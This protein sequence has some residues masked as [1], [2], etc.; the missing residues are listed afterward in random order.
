MLTCWNVFYVERGNLGVIKTLIN[1][2]TIP[3]VTV[4][5]EMAAYFT[6]DNTKQRTL[7]AV[8]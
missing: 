2:F 5:H 8:L 7:K 4:F 3:F 6:V 1:N